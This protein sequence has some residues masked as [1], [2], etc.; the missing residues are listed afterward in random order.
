MPIFL[1]SI[2]FGFIDII[3]IN[4]QKICETYKFNKPLFLIKTSEYKLTYSILSTLKLVIVL[5]FP[6]CASL[7]K[8]SF[9]NR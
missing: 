6:F 8:K 2:K 1:T 5:F 4:E 3:V 9:T 7:S